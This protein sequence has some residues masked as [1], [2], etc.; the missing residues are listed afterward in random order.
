MTAHMITLK[1][2]AVR[3]ACVLLGAVPGLAAAQTDAPNPPAA[4]ALTIYSSA[5]PGAI[6]PE[7]YAPGARGRFRGEIP[8][9]AVIKQERGFDLG[10]GRSTIRFSD[11][12]ARIDPTT[13]AFISLTDPDTTRVLEQNFQFDLVSQEKLMERFL[14][15]VITVE[16]SHGEKIETITGTLLSTTN[17]GIILKDNAGQVRIINHYSNVLFPELPGGLIT[18]PTLVWDVLTEQPG[19]HRTR[20]TYQTDGITWWADYNVVFAEGA[21]AN[22]GLLDIGAWVSIINQSGATYTDAGL[23]LVAGDVHRVPRPMPAYDMRVMRARAAPEEAMPGFEQKP[24]FE[25]HLY[26]LGRPTTLPDNSTKQLELFETAR[27]VPCEKVLVYD[28]LGQRFRHMFGRP[29]TDRGFGTESDKRVDIYLE[30]KN[31]EAVGMGM[32]LPA[33]RIRVSKLDPADDTLEFI[34]EDAI[35]HTPKDEKV[36]IKLGT[37][38]DVVGERTQVDFRVDTQRNWM[39]ETIEV[40]VRNHKD[41]DVKVIVKENLYRWMNWEITDKTQPF[42]KIDARTVHFPVTIEP[43]GEAVVRYT[44]RYTW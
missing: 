42:E 19:S 37:A 7:L 35:D 36:L 33:G 10:S 28:G 8:G 25:Y 1:R 9:H 29:M 44:V 5:L 23:K 21:D 12:A 13:V 11:V 26:T 16:Q 27:Q 6:P 20:V 17:G 32:P 3:A 39:Q 30:F 31:E 2:A 38:F 18:R 24:F 43:S 41:E 22:S 40:K 15:Q 34:G 14:D 4:T